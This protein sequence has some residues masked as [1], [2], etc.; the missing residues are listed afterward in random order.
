VSALSLPTEE[1]DALIEQD[2][3]WWAIHSGERGGVGGGGGDEGHVNQRSQAVS[4]HFEVGPANAWRDVHESWAWIVGLRI[5][6]PLVSFFFGAQ[7]L[8]DLRRNAKN[9]QKG[10]DVARLIC[11]IEAHILI[12]TA[13]A[14]SCGQVRDLCA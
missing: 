7:A 8:L 12:W 1:L 2:K 13:I 11:S 6:V 9:K 10:S 3:Q 5:M 4:V 14:L